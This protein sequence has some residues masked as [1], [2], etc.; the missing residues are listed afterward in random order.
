MG[1]GKIIVV[2]LLIFL[3]VFYG[4]GVYVVIVNEYLVCCDVEEV[5]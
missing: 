2:F 4:K 5:G 3:N 1:E